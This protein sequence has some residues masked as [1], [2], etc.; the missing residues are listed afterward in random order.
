[1]R[2]MRPDGIIL[3]HTAIFVRIFEIQLPSIGFHSHHVQYLLNDKYAAVFRSNV[4]GSV[5][6]WANVW[7]SIFRTPSFFFG[8]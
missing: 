7:N 2:E 3:A 8:W 5:S 1:M 6:M 4:R